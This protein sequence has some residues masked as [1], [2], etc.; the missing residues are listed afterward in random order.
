MTAIEAPQPGDFVA[1][2]AGMPGPEVDYALCLERDG[3]KALL[4]YQVWQ[5]PGPWH[6][7][8]NEVTG[9]HKYGC[10]KTGRL[11][12]IGQ[13]LKDKRKEMFPE[14]PVENPAHDTKEGTGHG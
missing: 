8:W 4:C 11:D 13:A 7:S 9:A 5:Q 14:L 2:V 3:D 6:Q 1:W 12:Q 10:W